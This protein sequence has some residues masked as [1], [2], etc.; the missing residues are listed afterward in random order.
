MSDAHRFTP[1][2]DSDAP[3]GR[4]PASGRAGQALL[5]ILFA[6]FLA[7]NAGGPLFGLSPV[8]NNIFGASAV[9]CLILLGVRA[10]RARQ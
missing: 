6:V 4:R 5:W 1:A 8:L 9:G 3:S 10:W 2:P 7:L